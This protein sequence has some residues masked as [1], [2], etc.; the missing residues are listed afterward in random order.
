MSSPVDLNTGLLN[1][2]ACVAQRACRNASRAPRASVSVLGLFGINA[3]IQHQIT[4]ALIC[5]LA[6]VSGTDADRAVALSFALSCAAALELFGAGA[7]RPS[8]EPAVAHFT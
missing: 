7:K 3:H 1:F 8:V 4:A 2:A 5:W 6:L